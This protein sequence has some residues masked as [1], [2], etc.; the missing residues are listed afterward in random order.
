MLPL[1][2]LGKNHM[3]WARHNRTSRCS[4]DFPAYSIELS[5]NQS[6]Y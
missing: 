6:A 2:T 3:F 5:K 1:A 4:D